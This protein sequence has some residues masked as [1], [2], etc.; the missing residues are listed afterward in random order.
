MT[1]A[2][3][4]WKDSLATAA[5]RAYEAAHGSAIPE[6]RRGLRVRMSWRQALAGG[7]G[8]VLLVGGGWWLTRPHA[9][10]EV[11]LAPIS[12]SPAPGEGA[13]VVLDVSGAVEQP[14]LVELPAGSRVADALDAAG[15]A[16][17][18][19][20]LDALNL[21]RR[22]SDGEQILV[23]HR[24]DAEHAAASGLININQA[25]ASQLEQLPGV[26]P[27]LA[28]RIVADRDANGPFR[29]LEDL[30]RVSGVGDAIVGALEGV[31]TV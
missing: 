25:D 31:A 20:V 28:E 19:A 15:G 6:T 2:N 26:G 13:V 22:V 23:P 9:G 11:P 4:R 29:S 1:E 18:D 3:D 8:V 24:G 12:G 10:V 7:L 16:S 27:V 5:A 17:A 14:G 21:A 30:G